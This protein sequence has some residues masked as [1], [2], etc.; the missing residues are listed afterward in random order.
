MA[1]L[2]MLKPRIVAR[3]NRLKTQGYR[4]PHDPPGITGPQGMGARGHSEG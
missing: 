4:E 1:R 3:D 2:K